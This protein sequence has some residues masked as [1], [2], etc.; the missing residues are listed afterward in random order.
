MIDV[1]KFKTI[2]TGSSSS[3]EW[4]G[5][6]LPLMDKYNI[7]T[8]DRIAG[9]MSQAMHESNN[10]KVLEENLKYTWKRLREIFPK[11]FPT[12][13]MAKE[14]E[15]NPEKIANRVYSDEF[16]TGK[17]GNTKPGDGWKFRGGGIF[18]LTGR[19]NYEKFGKSIGKTADE[20]ADYV[21]TK[22]GAFESAVW[23]WNTNNL[24]RF[25]DKR[26]IAGLSKAV[27]G[28]N[29]GLNERTALYDKISKIL[30][31]NKI[32]VVVESKTP[33]FSDLKRGSKGDA[34]KN[35][36]N[37]L[38]VTQ[39]GIFGIGVDM[40]VKGWQKQNGFAAD[41]VVNQLQYNK[42]INTI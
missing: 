28:G 30:L 26:D 25:A 27:N 8:N 21:R 16:R 33:E 19:N 20:A 1:D 38:G 41:G 31:E 3:S 32:V 40:A 2:L 37:V 39:D 14:Y 23:Y 42:I 10:F 36:Q 34:V 18:Q 35:I 15:K 13:V 12:D 6:A 22:Q 5:I 4:A 17:L 29:I 11:Y 7:N 9:F 24:N